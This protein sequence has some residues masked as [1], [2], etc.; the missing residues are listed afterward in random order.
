M[1]YIK[2]YINDLA[3]FKK[4]DCYMSYITFLTCTSYTLKK[5]KKKVNCGDTIPILH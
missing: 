3:L 5:K 2:L 1:M 4:N